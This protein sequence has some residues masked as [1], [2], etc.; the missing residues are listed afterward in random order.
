MKKEELAHRFALKHISFKPQWLNACIECLTRRVGLEIQCSDDIFDHLFLQFLYSNLSD[1]LNPEMRIPVHAAKVVIIKRMVFQMVS[2]TN[3]SFSLYE[4]LSEN[5]RN[6]DDLSWFHGGGTKI[7]D[8]GNRDLERDHTFEKNNNFRPQKKKRGMLKLELTDGVN[9]VK[10]IELEEIFDLTFLV[11]GVKIILTGHVKCRR[12]VLLLDNSNCDLLG[13]RI[14]S[15][16]IDKVKQLSMQ[17][18][19]DLDAE[20]KRRQESLA[21]SASHVSSWN[22]KKPRKPDRSKTDSSLNQS[23]LSPFL[24]KTN[25]KTGEITNPP[26]ISDPP[27]N[28]ESTENWDFSVEELP[29]IHL[30]APEPSTRLEK[31]TKQSLQPPV[32]NLSSLILE[33]PI[34]HEVQKP[35]NPLVDK[36]IDSWAY[37]PTDKLPT[38]RQETDGQKNLNVQNRLKDPEPKT[39]IKKLPGQ[40][41]R[42]SSNS[43]QEQLSLCRPT[44]GSPSMPA[45]KR[46]DISEWVWDD[47]K[48]ETEQDDTLL[49]P[50]KQGKYDSVVEIPQ[51]LLKDTAKRHV[52]DSEV[53]RKLIFL[54]TLHGPRKGIEDFRRKEKVPENA[55]ITEHFATVK[56]PPISKAKPTGSPKP[57]FTLIRDPPIQESLENTEITEVNSGAAESVEEMGEVISITPV[58]RKIQYHQVEEEEKEES[59]DYMNQEGEQDSSIMECTIEREGRLE[60]EK[61][62]LRGRKSS[63]RHEEAEHVPSF[64]YNTHTNAPCYSSNY[65]HHLESLEQEGTSFPTEH[66]SAEAIYNPNSMEVSE[67]SPRLF[68]PQ[69]WNFPVEK[70]QPTP[71]QHPIMK[72]KRIKTDPDERSIMARLTTS[73]CTDAIKNKQSANV[74]IYK[75]PFAKRLAS[76]DSSSEATTQLFQRM[77]DLQIVPLANALVNRKFWL[78]SKIFVVMPTICHQVHELRSD[79]VDWLFQITVTDTSAA[80]VKCRVAT[81]LLSRLFGFTVQQCKTLFDTN[82]SE[83]L[84]A[85]KSDAERKLVGFNRLDLLIWIEVPPEQDKLPLVVDVKTISDALNI[86]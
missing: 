58:P 62:G 24:I 80:S 44:L 51:C 17:L 71:S 4:Q 15:I 38:K 29:P 53:D 35:E 59:F 85:K 47:S 25:R 3:I 10:A 11:P 9:T 28:P 6:D 83:E 78:M 13:G 82:Q 41:L 46:K 20:K 72:D 52:D 60:L 21:Q 30:S 39:K 50:P 76:S 7:H 81:D 54:R 73:R 56:G 69:S 37:K 27:A 32:K 86:L 19:V 12:G 31:H 8:E 68:Y 33:D 79:G 57:A 26:L 63:M 77:T 18:N 42:A 2:Y 45:D 22:T 67:E 48:G 74:Q 34:Q 5:T 66:G 14:Q 75:A 16:E 64:Q 70:L 23:T 55:K 49:P 61:W 65:M 43:I 84:R 40:L 36:T 1:S